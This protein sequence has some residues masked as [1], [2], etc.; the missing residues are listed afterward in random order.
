[1]DYGMKDF[2]NQIHPLHEHVVEEYLSC[3]KPVAY[4]RRSVLTQEGQTE[5]FMY[6]VE[7]GIQRSYYLRED[8]EHVIAFT[9]PPSFSGIPESFFSQTPSK[10]FL[11]CITDSRLLK[12]SYEDHQQMMLKH[13]EI[14]TLFRR[15]TEM[16]LIG[17]MER[18]FELM[19]F[20]MEE[21]FRSFAK[22]SPHLLNMVPHKYLAS[23]LRIDP[24]NFSKLM[25]K[26][27]I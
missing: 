6:F 25:G 2:L 11:E 18:H 26:I 16:L 8:K 17:T 20:D 24:T 10:Y 4:K 9:Y 3:W 14:E 27:S 21:R 5:R 1:M 15:G 23:Y 19:A 12:I 7:E 13:R 22:R